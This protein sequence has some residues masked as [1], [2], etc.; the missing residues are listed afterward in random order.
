MI[1]LPA[2]VF[3]AAVM[4]LGLVAGGTAHAVR[5]PHVVP[6]DDVESEDSGLHLLREAAVAGRSRGYSGTQYVTSWGAS[7]AA[8]AV[9]EVRNVPG[10]GLTVRAAPSGASGPSGS[11]R[12]ASGSVRNADPGTPAGGM[13]SPSEAMLEVLARNYRVVAAGEGFACGRPARLVNVLRPDGTAAARYWLDEAGGPVLRRE[14]M[15]AEGRVVSAGAFVDLTLDPV[16]RSAAPAL[17]AGGLDLAELPRLAAGGWSFPRALPGRLELFAAHNTPPG[18]LYLG[19]SD[20]LSVV[21]VFIQSGM[22]DEERLQGWHAERRKGHTIWVRDPAGQ[23]TIW[24]SGGHVYTVFAD[25]PADMVDTAVAA[26]PHEPVPD[27]WTRLGR[28]ASRL[29]SWVNP[30][31]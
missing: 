16:A 20:G 25:A 27:L 21:S 10:K 30:F 4:L 3:L 19:Y 31:G 15:D 9:L 24:A 22:L 14:L 1:R 7:G 17:A 13:S 2:T 18:Y 23:E 29:L 12:N 11:V 5:S 28:G 6:P 26:L 8:S